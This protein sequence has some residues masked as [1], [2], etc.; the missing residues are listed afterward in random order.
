M[1]YRIT[2]ECICCGSCLH[3][4]PVEAIT[5]EPEIFVIDPEKCNDCVG[6]FEEPQCAAV[7]GVDAC[8]QDFFKYTK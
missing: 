5:E 1:V 8:I 3:E 4:C 2:S 7:C 6:H